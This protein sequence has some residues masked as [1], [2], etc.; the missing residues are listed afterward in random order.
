VLSA[1]LYAM[2]RPRKSG[3]RTKSGRLS[4]AFK[5]P[6]RD[7]GTAELQAKKLALVNGA[8]DPA[9]SASAA[10]ILLAHHVLDRE[11]HS[12]AERYH[13]AYRLSFGMPNYGLCLISDRS[14][15]R[16]LTMAGCGYASD[17]T[18]WWRC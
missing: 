9:L 4:R 13:R 10:S 5:S 7:V 16:S 18:L 17:S 12:A 6:V 1:I 14:D 8:A 3:A 15:G 2:L 11:Q